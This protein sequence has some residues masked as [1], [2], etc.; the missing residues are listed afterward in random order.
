MNK[1]VILLVSGIFCFSPFTWGQ[2][3]KEK[4]VS[5]EYSHAVSLANNKDYSR[6]ITMF[7]RVLKAQP[8]SPETLYY[9]GYC[10]LNTSEGPDSAIIYF[11]RGIEA[12]PE[13]DKNSALG[14]D[15]QY[16]ISKSYHKLLRPVEAIASFQKLLTL[17]PEEEQL[18][19]KEINR[20]IE[21]CQNTIEL[22]KKPVKLEV[23]NLGNTVNTKYDDHSPL[24]TID[25]STL[26]YTSRRASSYSQLMPDG[27]YSEKI[28]YSSLDTLSGKWEKA[29]ILN[30]LF[31]REGHESCVSISADGQELY[32]FRNDM[33]GQNL[34]V[35]LFDGSS[36]TEPFKLPKPINSDFNETHATLNPDKSVL[37]FT[38][39]R[40]GGFGGLDIYQIRKLPDGE[41]AKPLNLG[42]VVNTEYDEETPM[43]H[44]D[45]KTLYFASEGH[46]SMGNF[47][48]FFTKA[49]DDSTWTEPIN[50]GYPINTVD[51]DF[52]FV[53]TIVYN[54]AY[55]ASARFND[56]YGK[57]DIYFIEYEEPEESRLAVFTGMILSKPEDAPLENIRLTVREKNSESVIGSYR[58]HPGT[59]KYV[60][61]VEADKH[62]DLLFEGQDFENFSTTMDVRPEMAYNKALKA[63]PMQKVVMQSTL[64]HT[65]NLQTAEPEAKPDTSD[66][67]PY[68]TVQILTRKGPV[69]SWKAFKGLDPELIREYK[70]KNNM[71]RYGYGQFKG[72]KAAVKAKE[73]VLKVTNFE[74]SFI[75]DI[76]QY[77][78]LLEKSDD[79]KK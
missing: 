29:R 62:Y 13:S 17:L 41:W 51:D 10:Y 24:V 34:Y 40:P 16:S 25:G 21:M 45:G 8:N 77:D 43:L 69:P 22:L 48:I 39:D 35:S 72:Y 59:G 56:T 60:V 57:S 23:K 66:G 44:P 50:M 36:W 30:K 14:V 73:N 75:R 52:F 53:P 26:F 31:K 33:D 28:Y 61:I 55:Y 49:N 67:I 74:D 27:Q 54:K 63:F 9:I 7:K 47:D 3:A 42:P 38:S 79:Q 58:P 68:Y 20:E 11:N 46:N 1:T 70:C 4:A 32:L 19:R 37:Y 71:Y 78:D 6:A 5:K 64:T 65:T 18:F 15:L 76:T 2:K 12:L